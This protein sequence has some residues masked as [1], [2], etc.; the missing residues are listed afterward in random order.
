MSP[1]T[2]AV[3]TADSFGVSFRGRQILK[4]ATAWTRAG[5]VTAVL[6][7]NGCGKTTLIRAALGLGRRD[8]G[9]VHFADRTWDRPRL[10]A[11]ARRGL[12]YLPDRGL[13]SWRRT[14]DWHFRA[15]GP[16]TNSQIDRAA[17][18]GLEIE[19]FRSRKA[20]TMSG[21]ERRRAELA[22]ALTRQPICLIADEPLAEVSPR[23]RV[24]VSNAIR[25]LAAKGCAILVT[26]H[27]V[28]DL[29]NLADLVVWMVGGTT[30]WLGTPEEARTHVQFRMDYLSST[31]TY[32]GSGGDTAC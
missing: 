6:G 24:L 18:E 15:M 1:G 9:I 21:G 29:L 17:I 26:G 4:S 27:E 19:Q 10:S 32:P 3:F 7:R 14:V 16:I 22:L 30:H 31:R 25:R 23:D 20:K 5:S 8:F 12:F 2:D 11:L 13:L 28:D